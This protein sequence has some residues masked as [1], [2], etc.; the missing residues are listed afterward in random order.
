MVV[1]TQ[2]GVHHHTPPGYSTAPGRHHRCTDV[3]VP[4]ATPGEAGFLPNLGEAGFLPN[5]GEAG[6]LEVLGEAGFLEVLGEAGFSKLRRS[7]LQ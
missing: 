2:G 5:L 6:F 1:Y 7:R 3:I 4:A